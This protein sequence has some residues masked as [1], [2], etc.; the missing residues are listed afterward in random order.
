M[1]F[2]TS[3]WKS[4]VALVG[5]FIATQLPS[6]EIMAQEWISGAI[7]AIFV[8]FAVWLKSNTQPEI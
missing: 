1:D 2:I 8:A 3:S 6:I 5:T 7:S 4:I